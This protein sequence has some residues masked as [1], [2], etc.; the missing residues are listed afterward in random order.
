M[1]RTGQLP[2]HV[3][4]EEHIIPPAV[5]L[6]DR[7]VLAKLARQEITGSWKR[8]NRSVLVDLMHQ[9]HPAIIIGI[10]KQAL[11]GVVASSPSGAHWR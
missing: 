9:V 4:R 3:D 8:M 2:Q 10:A 1:G 6:P 11:C 5:E 7:L